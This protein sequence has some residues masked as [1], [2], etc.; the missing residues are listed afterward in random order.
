MR[1]LTELKKGIQEGESIAIFTH[2]SNDHDT[3][4][5]ALALKKIIEQMGKNSVVFVDKMPNEGIMRFVHNQSF[6]ISSEKKFDVGITVDCSQLKMLGE[7]SSKVFNACAKTFNIDHHQD[8]GKF[9]KYNWVKKGWSSCCEV[10]YWL[11][12]NHIAMD[13]EIAEL[14]YA[15]IYMDCG[16]FTYSSANA[17]THR[18]VGDLMRYCPNINEN[19][20]VC[21]GISG[22]E[23]F[24]ITKKAFKS[25][26]FYS[27]KQIAV[28]VLYKQDFEDCKCKREDGKFILSYLHNVKGVLIAISISEDK[29]NEWR[30]S[31]RSRSSNV[32]VANIA[33]RFNGGG[34]FKPL[35]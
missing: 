10:L 21:F 35:G 31:L 25:V 11:F 18:C 7:E 5:S 30:V 24:A 32:N 14:L 33:H 34:I 13:S 12:K 4:C 22:Q 20:F 27:N 19:F 9:A 29:E 17:K 28:S 15:G 1:F 6:E 3:I 16:A 26:K 23:N 2:K 8:N